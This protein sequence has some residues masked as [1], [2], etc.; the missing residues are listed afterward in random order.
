MESY[1]TAHHLIR[2][3]RTDRPI[4]C[5][6]EHSV[7][8]REMR[9]LP[10]GAYGRAFRRGLRERA[11]HG[12]PQ[13]MCQWVADGLHPIRHDPEHWDDTLG[14]LHRMG[15]EHRIRIGGKVKR[16]D[17]LLFSLYDIPPDIWTVILL[18]ADLETIKNWGLIDK[19]MR[20]IFQSPV[21]YFDL[22]H[23]R[24]T[25]KRVARIE[26]DVF[27]EVEWGEYRKEETKIVP[28][29]PEIWKRHIVQLKI[30]GIGRSNIPWSFYDEK[31]LLGKYVE[32]EWEGLER[33]PRL[34]HL[35]IKDTGV[36]TLPALPQLKSL[37]IDNSY[38]ILGEKLVNLEKLTLIMYDDIIP[39]L[40]DSKFPKLRTLNTKLMRSDA[41][42]I[43][44]HL[45][46]Q[47][48]TL[49]TG[50]FDEYLRKNPLI[51]N[52]LE[53]LELHG[54][55]HR[56]NAPLFP[57]VYPN[58]T[59]FPKL[60]HLRFYECI[61]IGEF[62]MKVA[63]TLESLFLYNIAEDDDWKYLQF[64]KLKALQICGMFGEY[65]HLYSNRIH[66]L[67]ELRIRVHLSEDLV[68]FLKR[69]AP[70]LTSLALNRLQYIDNVKFPRVI[71]LDL[72]GDMRNYAR[73]HS[74]INF[75]IVKHAKVD[76]TQ[77][78]PGEGT[79]GRTYRWTNT[80]LNPK[81]LETLHFKSTLNNVNG[82]KESFESMFKN[83]TLDKL[84]QLTM[85]I[86]IPDE[87][88]MRFKLIL[89][90]WFKR[91]QVAAPQLKQF[92]IVLIR[93]MNDRYEIL[94]KRGNLKRNVIEN[95]R[96]IDDDDWED[97]Y[98]VTDKVNGLIGP[99]ITAKQEKELR[100]KEELS[101]FEP[102]DERKH[103]RDVLLPRK[104]ALG[105]RVIRLIRIHPEHWAYRRI[106]RDVNLDKGSV[107]FI[108][109]RELIEYYAKYGMMYSIVD[110]SFRSDLLVRDIE[111]G[112]FVFADKFRP[113]GN[114]I[115]YRKSDLKRELPFHRKDKDIYPHI[116][117]LD[118]DDPEDDEII[119]VPCFMTY[120][121][122]SEDD[123]FL[124]VRRDFRRLGYA[125]YLVNMIKVRRVCAVTSAF[126]F[127]KRMGFVN[128][129]VK[130]KGNSCTVMVIPE[131]LEMFQYDCRQA[132]KEELEYQRECK[133]DEEEGEI[134]M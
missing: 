4:P 113:P 6:P 122:A 106:I 64:D 5:D 52:N 65:P 101:I 96:T 25:W 103:H 99:K 128:T 2:I 104:I 43:L 71:N 91:F 120:S 24:F 50:Y 124:W 10:I 20:T 56:L 33:L 12:T 105:N 47:L 80:G 84:Y 15:E 130:R 90:D 72:S 44:R 14:C 94:H 63:S 68:P 69:V 26:K 97:L 42:Y 8:P 61:R 89:N 83:E 92:R 27:P 88:A 73:D 41:E 93:E 36:W 85:L 95:L 28:L 127:W 58:V 132:E 123:A 39:G 13:E 62:L 7:I 112:K 118:E 81:T 131:M 134:N 100:N 3:L 119:I 86:T 77:T 114:L 16:H 32:K 11:R 9:M 78:E 107:N 48:E 129:G 55:Q 30:D 17:P 60:R 19:T 111:T 76:W 66:T 53:T 98:K 125:K 116:T 40:E 34:R 70:Y 102:V 31:P 51:F 82:I 29:I 108:G 18:F 35:W 115:P 87:Y 109:N 37:E 74:W 45:A 23:I 75:P 133:E 49:I 21:Y 117:T 1:I 79:T 46:P 57:R 121:S 22:S 38:V 54:H 59:R 110:E 67:R 126:N